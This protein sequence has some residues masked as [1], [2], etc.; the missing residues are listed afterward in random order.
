MKTLN[1]IDLGETGYHDCWK[2]QREVHRRRRAGLCADTLLLTT[3]RHVYTI[4]K[5]GDDNHLLAGAAELL[6]SGAE[7]VHTDRG[8]DI[9]YHGPG[10]L[11]VYPVIDLNDRGA[12]VH[13]YLRDLEEVIIRTIA[14]HAL[15]G[16]REP[17]YTGVWVG[18]EKI[19]AI[20]VKVGGWVTM[21]GF[22]LNVFTDLGFFERIIP[23]GITH[24]GVTSMEKCLGT[25]IPMD[26]V[27]DPAVR[28]FE[29]IFSLA[30]RPA[31]IAELLRQELPMM[32]A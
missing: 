13:R 9:T 2:L 32:N 12:D 6:K 17:G 7:V 19:A 31:G 24:R 5:T 14:D 22:A 16:E 10:Q 4:G 8:G 18:A 3:H 30:G 11:V 25:L 15:K 21:H 27:R 29:K 26:A 28:H 23:C 1:I 20:G